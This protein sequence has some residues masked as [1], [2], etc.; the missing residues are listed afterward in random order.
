MDYESLFAATAWLDA[1][2]AKIL[3]LGGEAGG[4]SIFPGRT[5]ATVRTAV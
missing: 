1:S 2:E 3:A 5:V 4:R